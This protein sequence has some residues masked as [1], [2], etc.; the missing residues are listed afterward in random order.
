MD[1]RAM[2]VPELA[3]IAGTRAAAGVGIG[4]LIADRLSQQERLVI[5]TALLTL[6]VAT[7]VPILMK[8]LSKP[9]LEEAPL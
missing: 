3:F 2:S 4:L 7:T 8:V 1:E 5:G 9:V 6:G